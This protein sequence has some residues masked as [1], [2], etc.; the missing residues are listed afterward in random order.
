LPH[1]NI[2]KP[3]KKINGR[4]KKGKSID[5]KNP[6]LVIIEI[7]TANALWEPDI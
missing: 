2:L 3:D 7:A 6:L 1:F 5:T 4:G